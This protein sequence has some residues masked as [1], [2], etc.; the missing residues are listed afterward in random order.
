MKWLKRIGLVTALSG[1]VAISPACSTT[2]SMLGRGTSTWTLNSASVAT[3]ATGEIKVAAGK[4]G[5]HEIKVE[6]K[7]MA[8]PETAFE[9]TSTYVVW[10]K[11]DGAPARNIGVLHPDK[12]RKAKLEATTPYTSFE[13]LVTAENVPNVTQ[14]SGNMVLDRKVEV[15]T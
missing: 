4:D 2:N 1:A 9:G 3:A 8:P 7:H 13:V 5:N 11:P 10:L 12:D 6:V 14:P 15:A